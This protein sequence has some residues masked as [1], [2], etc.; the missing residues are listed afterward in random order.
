MC[1]KKTQ[2]THTRTHFTPPEK[3]QANCGRAGR[4]ELMNNVNFQDNEKNTF[5]KI[6]TTRF[7][8][9]VWL[10]RDTMDA[11]IKHAANSNR[12]CEGKDFH[13]VILIVTLYVVSPKTPLS[14]LLCDHSLVTG[15]CPVL[16]YFGSHCKSSD[17]LLQWVMPRHILGLCFV[18]SAKHWADFTMCWTTV[19]WPVQPSE[20][21]LITDS[22]PC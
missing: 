11:R 2:H 13:A 15:K 21:P 9:K 6:E 18:S 16:F 8:G 4:A 14:S 17:V 1:D 20:C 22:L 19:V 3:S 5:F 12:L 7:L 10:L